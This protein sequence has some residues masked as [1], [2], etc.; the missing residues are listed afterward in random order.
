MIR[1]LVRQSSRYAIASRGD[2]TPLI[3]V[4]HGNYAAAYMFALKD[5]FN[6]NEIENTIGS[7]KLRIQYEKQ[8]ID[9]QDS[10][11]KNVAKYCPQYAGEIDFLTTLAGQI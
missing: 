4:L 11:T 1:K 3:S 10:A 9:I 6:D 8:I 7:K 5:L 2:K